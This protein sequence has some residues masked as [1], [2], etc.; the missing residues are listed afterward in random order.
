VRKDHILN[1][2]VVVDLANATRVEDLGELTLRHAC[3]PGRGIRY[4]L[5]KWKSSEGSGRRPFYARSLILTPH[6][7]LIRC[8]TE[9]E[10]VSIN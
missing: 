2:E 1:V 3:G 8:P 6:W 5:V 4:V 10:W 9:A 7:K